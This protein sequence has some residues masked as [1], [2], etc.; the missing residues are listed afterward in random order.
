MGNLRQFD[1]TTEV[2]LYDSAKT[3]PHAALPPA[4]TMPPATLPHDA[5][6]LSAAL[7]P[8]A[9][10]SK[11]A[12]QF[13]STTWDKFEDETPQAIAETRDE[14][15]SEITLVAQ[16]RTRNVRCSSKLCWSIFKSFWACLG[17]VWSSWVPSRHGYQLKVRSPQ[18]QHKRGASC[19]AA[20]Q[21]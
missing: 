3:M 6:M 14:A 21:H 11:S 19:S 12:E 13:V 16:K 15:L 20:G 5:M 8:A 9:M 10:M 7:P 18:K 17:A 2:V 1:G 4:A